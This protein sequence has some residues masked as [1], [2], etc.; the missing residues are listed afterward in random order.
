MDSL[1]SLPSLP[2]SLPP[3]LHY[4][5]F[6]GSAHTIVLHFLPPSLPP[7][8]PP[9]LGIGR[10]WLEKRS[11]T[12]IGKGIPTLVG[13]DS[14]ASPVRQLCHSLTFPP[15]LPPSL[16]PFLGI[17]GQ[18]LEKRSNRHR[19]WDFFPCRPR[20]VRVAY[21]LAFPLTLPPSL[22]PSLPPYPL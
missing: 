15:S 2:H 1:V 10:Q 17:G 3:S 20:L 22:P 13:P 4:C 6:W 5:L 21:A 14:F 11:M 12:G 19:N 9:F 7:S 18:W 16:P 8:L